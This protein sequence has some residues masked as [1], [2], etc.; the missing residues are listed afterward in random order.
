MPQVVRVFFAVDFHPDVKEALGQYVGLLKKQS[1]SQM[2]R[3]TRPEN[4]HI[5]LQFLAEI[6]SAD[7]P[8]LLERVRGQIAT[9]RQT[10]F[11]LKGLCLFPT[12][13]RPRVIVAEL[14]PETDL[15]YLSGLIGE[16]MKSSGYPVEERLYRPHVTLGRL[17]YVR[18][19]DL[20]FMDECPLPVM[21]SILLKEVV[22]FRSDPQPEGSCYTPLER[23]ELLPV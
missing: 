6:K 2:I 19:P 5:T 12:R 17:K 15:S 4:F 11:Q 21:D 20:S 7:L 22:L 14:Y 18:H 10:R 13:Y 16:A 1:K 23:I 8:G 9:V 3:W